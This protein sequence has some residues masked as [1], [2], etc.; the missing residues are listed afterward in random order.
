MIFPDEIDLGS[1][2]VWGSSREPFPSFWNI[3]GSNLKV[4]LDNGSWRVCVCVRNRPS[5]WCR[6]LKTEACMSTSASVADGG[7]LNALARG[8]RSARWGIEAFCSHYCGR[9]LVT[10]ASVRI[11]DDES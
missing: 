7:Q 6:A 9:W 2:G 1:S 3:S 10:H 5:L 4:I 11:V 8:R